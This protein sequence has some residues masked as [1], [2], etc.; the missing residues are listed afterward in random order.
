MYAIIGA[1]GHDRGITATAIFFGVGQSHH[2]L[3]LRSSDRLL[4]HRK[5]GLTELETFGLGYQ[6]SRLRYD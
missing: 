6:I 4:N 2:I 3:R 5:S 1:H